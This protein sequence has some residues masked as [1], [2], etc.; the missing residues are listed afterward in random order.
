LHHL[1]VQAAGQEICRILHPDGVAVFFKPMRETKIM[2]VI[3]AIVLRF[4]KRKRSEET[5]TPLTIKRKSLLR[6]YFRVIRC[7]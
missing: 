5:E 3:K 1:D 2:D 7:R 6:P 4:V